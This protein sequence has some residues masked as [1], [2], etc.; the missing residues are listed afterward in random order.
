MALSTIVAMGKRTVSGMLCAGAEQFCD[1]SAAYRM[2]GAERIDKDALFSPVR[3]GVLERLGDDEPLTVMM[4]DTIVRKRG[5]K[6]YGTSWKR[7]PL[8]PH[9]CTNFVWA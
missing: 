1:W 9:F 8:G 6:V 2:F 3:N 7:D 4:D 5:R